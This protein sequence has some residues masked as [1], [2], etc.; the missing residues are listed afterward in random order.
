M[1]SWSSKLMEISCSL[2]KTPLSGHR[3]H[4]TL[5][6][7][8]L[9]C[10]KMATSFY[11]VLINALHGKAF[12]IRQILCYQDNLLQ[13]L[14]SSN[15]QNH[16]H[17]QRTSLSLA[18]TYNFPE[19]YDTSPDSYTNLSH[20]VGPELSNLTGDFVAVVDEEG[21]FGII[22]GSSLNGAVY[23]YKNDNDNGGL[24]S[25]TN[26]SGRPSVLQSLTLETNGNLCLYRW[27]NDVNG[28]RQLF[29]EWVVVSKPCDIAGICVNGI[30][31]LD[32]SRTNASSRAYQ[33]LQ[34]L[35]MM[36]SAGEIHL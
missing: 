11:M 1:Q 5:K 16:L 30:C 13:F 20:W 34:S 17:M 36:A 6:S 21:S 24:S 19:S 2:I 28:S 22:Y 4:Q 7:K 15:L 26:Q 35:A 29:P 3:I 23:M 12:H 33:E 31:N 27:D 25:A 8:Q 10:L 9:S 18:L 32:Q 14:S